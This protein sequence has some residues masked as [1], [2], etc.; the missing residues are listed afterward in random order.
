M[1]LILDS[2]EIREAIALASGLTTALNLSVPA[3]EKKSPAVVSDNSVKK[4]QE[5]PLKPADEIDPTGLAYRG[6]QLEQVIQNM[7]KRSH[8][9][10]AVVNPEAR[11]IASRISEESR[12]RDII[13]SFR[14]GLQ[15]FPLF[16]F[17]DQLKIVSCGLFSSFQHPDRNRTQ[18]RLLK[19]RIIHNS[20]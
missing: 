16:I 9:S 3:V 19:N 4:V 10:G 15:H 6:D 20:L 5:K 11:A 8:F 1:S 7:C 12:I 13:F 17:N 2:S 18:T 14:L